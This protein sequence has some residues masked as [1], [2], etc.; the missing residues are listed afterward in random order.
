MLC[1]IRH[2]S[3]KRPSFWILTDFFCCFVLV[4]ECAFLNSLR[5]KRV[6]EDILQLIHST[7]L[8]RFHKSVY[9][10]RVWSWTSLFCHAMQAMTMRNQL[11]I[12]TP[13]LDHLGPRS[14]PSCFY[15]ASWSLSHN[16]AFTSIL[17]TIFSLGSTRRRAINQDL[18][19]C[20]N[21]STSCFE[22]PA[23]KQTLTRCV[24]SGTVGGT[25]GLTM[26]PASWHHFAKLLGSGVRRANIGELGRD[27]G[28]CKMVEWRA[29]GWSV[30]SCS[31]KCVIRE[32]RWVISWI[33]SVS[34]WELADW[35]RTGSVVPFSMR[36]YTTFI[37]ARDG[38]DIAVV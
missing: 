30:R 13:L 15:L 5:P 8:C 20:T 3:P 10:F 9:L 38:N 28:S 33:W 17:S 34:R 26:N 7:P 37:A 18:I 14:R 11:L 2:P 4:V 35:G 22:F 6:S 12:S 24:P 16:L 27:C 31:Y 32:L 21:A 29:K 1:Q 19:L 23:C 36:P 25:I